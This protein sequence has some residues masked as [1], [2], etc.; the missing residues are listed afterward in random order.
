MNKY[1][2]ITEWSG[3]SRGK[4]EYT[5]EANSEEEAKELFWE[6]EPDSKKT[7]RDDTESEVES[8][9]LLAQSALLEV[10]G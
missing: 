3:Y 2:V 7:V 5:V 1:R 8:V 4:A 10:M 6:N 9:D